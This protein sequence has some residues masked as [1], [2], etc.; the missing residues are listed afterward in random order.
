MESTYQHLTD[1][2]HIKA[3]E[4]AA[5]LREPEEESPLTPQVCPTCNEQLP[6]NAKA[7]PACGTVFAPDAKAAQDQVNDM[8]DESKEE[9]DTLEEY[10][11]AD[12]IAEA[13]ND[14]PE[15]AA[16]LMDKLDALSN[17]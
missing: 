16:Q 15:L 17:E 13:V 6:P 3:A 7:C 12:K 2:D 14:D 9:A 10:K 4:V 8:V 1:E 5:D 11:D